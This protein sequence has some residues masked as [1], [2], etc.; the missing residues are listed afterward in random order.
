[1]ATRNPSVQDK[2]RQTCITCGNEQ[3]FDL[4]DGDTESTIAVYECQQC[5]HRAKLQLD[6]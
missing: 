4:V 1:M 6:P 3:W 5:G 2:I